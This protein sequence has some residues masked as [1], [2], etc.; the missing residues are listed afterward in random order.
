MENKTAAFNFFLENGVKITDL[1]ISWL[2]L[3]Q[4]VIIY[5]IFSCFDKTY[6]ECNLYWSF[7]NYFLIRAEVLGIWLTA[8]KL[9]GKPDFVWS[10]YFLILS[11]EPTKFEII[12][13]Q[14]KLCLMT[15]FDLQLIT[16]KYCNLFH[17]TNYMRKQGFL[18]IG[19][20]DKY[21]GRNSPVLSYNSVVGNIHQP[22]TVG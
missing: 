9:C 13:K 10:Y 3:Y 14:I 12:Q 15:Y 6:W 21:W 19:S 7:H 16:R 22:A 4:R 1:G 5:I 20:Q 8:S 17:M 11:G 18:F 2:T